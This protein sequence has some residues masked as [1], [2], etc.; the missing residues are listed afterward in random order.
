MLARRSALDV[1]DLPT[2]Y[3]LPGLGSIPALYD[4]QR[5]AIPSARVLEWADPHAD[6]PLP[7]YVRRIAALIDTDAPFFLGGV[8]FGGMLACE[9]AKIKPPLAVLMI[10]GVAQASEVPPYVMPIAALAATV[11]PGGILRLARH[12][13]L[14]RYLLGPMTP[15]SMPILNRLIES[16][17]S[18]LI[19]WQIRSLSFW[20][21]ATAP[22]VQ[23]HRIHGRLDRVLPPRFIKGIDKLIE[24]GGHLISLTHHHIVNRWLIETMSRE[25]R[26][27]TQP[28]PAR[29]RLSRTG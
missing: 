17:S 11:P 21:H 16:A 18:D 25:W 20:A 6:E 22:P 13:P 23:V 24:G 10:G 7:H 26:A 3:L 8:S 9:V 12:T 5:E 1:A 4:L 29:V 19:G 14:V 2:L 27:A 28:P 15:A